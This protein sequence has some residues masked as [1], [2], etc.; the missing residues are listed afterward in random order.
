MWWKY[1]S[2]SAASPLCVL[3][4]P[5]VGTSSATPPFSTS[6]WYCASNSKVQAFAFESSELCCKASIKKFQYHR[7]TEALVLMD[8]NNH[9]TWQCKWL[10]HMDNH[11][12]DRLLF[13]NKW[14]VY[15]VAGIYP[16]IITRAKIK[17]VSNSFVP[18]Q[19]RRCYIFD[20]GVMVFL[21]IAANACLAPISLGS[22]SA[23]RI[24][25]ATHSRKSTSA[26]VMVFHPWPSA[27]FSSLVCGDGM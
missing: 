17:V 19:T 13:R 2:C 10:K 7:L 14:K 23:Q 9:Y 20:T 21:L 27:P 5:K 4:Q 1:A 12:F 18:W 11:G 3:K 22:V 8:A 6:L 26:P 25:W 24:C 15:C 16:K